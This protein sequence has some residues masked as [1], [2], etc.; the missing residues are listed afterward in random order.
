MILVT[1][2]TGQLGSAVLTFLLK[3]RPPSQLAAL[4][5]DEAKAAHLAEKGI[6][7]RVGDYDDKAS[8]DR[9]MQGIDKVLLIAGTDED[10]RVE[11]HIRVIN[12]AQEAGVQLVAYT[13]RAL[14][15]RTTLAN[16][17][18]EGHFQTEDY[19]MASGLRYI[20][21]R[22]ILYMDTIP[23][24]VGPGV[25]DTGIRLPTGEG[26]VAFAL[27]NE[28]AEAI[29]TVLAQAG[30]DTK[31]YTLTGSFP[32]SFSD[33]AVALTNLSGK[34][35]SYTA[36]DK[37]AFETQMKS[38]SMPDRMIQRVT[39]FLTDIANG[40]EADVSPDLETLLGRK[41]ASLNEGL[42]ALY[43]V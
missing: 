6:D 19:L 34:D 17:L 22:N 31:I 38:R 8:L 9:S 39:G 10:K 23:Q 5:R 7:I 35:V 14:K 15:D 2:A 37:S 25:F 33:V 24:F 30:T 11:Q 43:N 13:S 40:Q 32:Y 29:A 26:R 16:R 12:A 42:N 27:R 41:P 18:M 28:M 4:V 21:F 36:L 20:L 3:K 1:G